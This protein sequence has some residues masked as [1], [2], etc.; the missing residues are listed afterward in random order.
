MVE[1]IIKWLKIGFMI[2]G[3]IVVVDFL[4]DYNNGKVTM[5]VKN[6]CKDIVSKF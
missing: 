6:I 3:I 2:I 4:F 5:N 1:K